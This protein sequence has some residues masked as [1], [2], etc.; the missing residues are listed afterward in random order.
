[1]ANKHATVDCEQ[2]LNFFARRSSRERREP[3]Q[4]TFARLLH[5][6]VREKKE[7]VEKEWTEG[8][9]GWQSVM[10][11]GRGHL[12]GLAFLPFQGAAEDQSKEFSWKKYK[13][14]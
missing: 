11:L 9:G 8:G 6:L 14:F 1:M 2:S 12:L 3:P 4:Q 5:C 7:D 10:T 13:E